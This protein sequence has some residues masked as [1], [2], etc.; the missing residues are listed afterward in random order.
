MFVGLELSFEDFDLGG[1][2]D[3]FLVVGGFGTPLSLLV[4]PIVLTHGKGHETFA[5]D[6][7]E[8]AIKV[9]V[10]VA[11]DV[12]FEVVARNNMI[13]IEEETDGIVNVGTASKQLSVVFVELT[14]DLVDIA[15]HRGCKYPKVVEVVAQGLSCGKRVD[16][17]KPHDDL[18]HEWAIFHAFEGVLVAVGE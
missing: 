16:R 11:L 12:R 6:S 3:N 10:E 7:G 2:G 13:G 14:V 9:V 8:V 1:H 5:D 15:M 17:G 18:V 4:E